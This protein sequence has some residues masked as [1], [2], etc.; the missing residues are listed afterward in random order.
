MTNTKLLCRTP[1]HKGYSSASQSSPSHSPGCCPHDGWNA[2]WHEWVALHGKAGS[3]LLMQHL[4]CP[5]GDT[6][7]DCMR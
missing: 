4:A 3:L 2:D 7:A 5:A 1:R 6:V